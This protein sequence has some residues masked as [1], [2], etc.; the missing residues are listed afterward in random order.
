MNWG[1]LKYIFKN[2]KLIVHI[3]FRTKSF[4]VMNQSSWPYATLF[5]VPWY[6]VRKWDVMN[7]YRMSRFRAR[8]GF[9]P[10]DEYVL[11]FEESIWR[12]SK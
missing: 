6:K 2:W 4:G 12:G 3:L 11:L 1:K 7:N 8:I 10:Y 9:I 5:Y